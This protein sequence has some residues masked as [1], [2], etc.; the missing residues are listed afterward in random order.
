MAALAGVFFVEFI[1]KN[2][3]FSAAIG[4]FAAERFEIFELLI[5]GTMLGCSHKCLPLPYPSFRRAGVI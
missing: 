1:R 2:F 3:S 4:A 5:T